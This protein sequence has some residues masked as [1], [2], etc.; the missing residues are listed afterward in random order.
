MWI[1]NLHRAYEASEL[2]QPLHSAS[3]TPD[4]ALPVPRRGTQRWLNKA[5]FPP[6]PFLPSPSRAH[7]FQVT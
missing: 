2:F 5:S 3:P 6:F 7:T 1:Q 4:P